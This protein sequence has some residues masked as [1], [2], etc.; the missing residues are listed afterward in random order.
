MIR[1]TEF[2]LDR[3]AV[4][5]CIYKNVS[6]EV[7]S[8]GVV[9]SSE[10]KAELRQFLDAFNTFIGVTEMPYYRIDAYVQGDALWILELNAS[11]VD[12]WGTAL[13]LCRVSGGSVDPESLVFPELFA[14]ESSDYLPELEVFLAEL[15]LVGVDGQIVPYQYYPELPTYIYGRVGSV[16]QKNVRP[17]EGLRL[18]DKRNL[19]Q[20]STL[21]QGKYVRVPR[22]Y[23]SDTD[24][25]EDIPASAVLKFCDKSGD[26]SKQA[27]T[28]VLIGKPEG[29]AKFLRRC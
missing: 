3:V 11:F 13:N 22:H 4:A 15:K 7:T 8:N 5:G 14:T 1:F 6:H 9:L 18:D 20:F 28:S 25:W 19:A 27:R 17:F 10:V 21:W 24:L 26:A 16:T 2:T 29:K 23:M 12:G